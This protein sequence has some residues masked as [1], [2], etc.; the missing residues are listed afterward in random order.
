MRRFVLA[1]AAAA[2]ASLGC[3]GSKGGGG[4]EP[5]VGDLK[6]DPRIHRAI[7]QGGG[8]KTAPPPRQIQAEPKKVSPKAAE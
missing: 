6:Q 8:D 2:L 1:V 5:K 4:D 7:R 3:E